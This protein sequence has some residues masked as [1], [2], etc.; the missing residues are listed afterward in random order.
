MKNQTRLLMF[1]L[2]LALLMLSG[3]GLVV[4]RELVASDELEHIVLFDPNDYQINVTYDPNQHNLCVKPQQLPTIKQDETISVKYVPFASQ[5]VVQ[6]R[7]GHKK[8]PVLFDTGNASL[9]DITPAHINENQLR[10]F[11]FS[12][13]PGLEDLHCGLAMIEE[14]TM[15]EMR[16]RQLPAMYN[17][18]QTDYQL[19]GLNI[20]TV[21]Q[22]K[23]IIIPLYV[24]QQ[25][26]YI[27]FNHKRKYMT[28]SRYDSFD[29][30]HSA[31]WKS[32][33]IQIEGQRLFI[34]TTLEG[35]DVRLMIDTGSA[36]DLFLT[37]KC[38]DRLIIQQ[39]KLQKAWKLKKTGFAP[40][41]G[42]H[43][44]YQSYLA[45]G[46]TFDRCR[47]RLSTVVDVVDEGRLYDF[48]VDNQF[49]G[50]IGFPFFENTLVV[51]DFEHKTLWA[52]KLKWSRFEQ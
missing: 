41:A 36:G 50:I 33:P 30:D 19:L 6:C 5:A 22:N 2:T 32:Y 48:L 37:K 8:Y 29:A 24:M 3:C 20:A 38:F 51:L 34:Q 15:G 44:P 31:D 17:P 43:F 10:V 27:A 9:T 7:I 11:P 49:D 1:A 42:G 25:F 16:I 52:K 28:F 47:H 12:T 13:Y 14:L 40:F 18:Q 4:H 45:W 35:M 23:D 26:R 39:P 21:A 46:L